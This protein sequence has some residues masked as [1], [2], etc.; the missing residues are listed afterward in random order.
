MTPARILIVEDERIIALDLS[1]RLKQLGYQVVATAASG[2]AAI[3]KASELK[4]DIV[5]MDIHIEGPMDGTEAAAEIHRRLGLPIV[6]LTAYAGD[7]ILARALA[8]LPFGYLVKPVETRDLHAAVQTAL[9][10]YQ[11]EQIVAVSEQRLKLALDAAGMGVWE[12]E[13]GNDRFTSAGPFNTILD[14]PPEEVDESLEHFLLRLVPD[15]RDRAR[16][17]LSGSSEMLPVGGTV[18][19]KFRYLG[20]GQIGWI[21]L[22][23]RLREGGDGRRI[24]GVIKDITERQRMEDE[25]RQSAM[26]FETIAE[27][28][29]T[30]DAEL[31][32]VSANLAFAEITGY[33]LDEVLGRKPE[34]F[35]HAR[36]HSDLFYLRLSNEEGGLWRGET[37]CRRKS[38]EVFPVDRKSVV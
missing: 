7:D 31:R 38:G 13:P 20:H 14:V 9:A 6:F 17:L 23:A 37:W 12:W 11:A 5:L 35:L 2:D 30:L 21:E 10:R 24:I 36:R 29:F 18:N 4:P 27:G 3:A 28:L 8:S 22:H 1:L 32:L 16:Q 19:G 34:D 33:P 15:D 26:A 25:L